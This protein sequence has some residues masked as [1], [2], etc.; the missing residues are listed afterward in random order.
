MNQKIII[1]LLFLFIFFI[2]TSYARR[3]KALQS[4]ETIMLFPDTSYET[5]IAIYKEKGF[6]TADGVIV[7]IINRFFER[8]EL[9]SNLIELVAEDDG[10]YTNCLGY[11]AGKKGDLS[12]REFEVWLENNNYQQ[13]E[14][15]GRGLVL[16][17]WS[18]FGHIFRHDI[19][20]LPQIWSGKEGL[21]K[22]FWSNGQN[23]IVIYRTFESSEIKHA[24][25]YLK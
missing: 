5:E 21:E 15:S 11:I 7:A 23:T 8:K 2:D 19:D 12:Q 17:K 3:V 20:F 24:G 9:D 18:K 10:T 6:L 16:S 1:I 22:E 4:K 13:I 25:I 14:G